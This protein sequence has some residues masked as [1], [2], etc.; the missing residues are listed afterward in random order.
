MKTVFVWLALMELLTPLTT[1]AKLVDK[2]VAI[3]PP[4][5]A[6]VAAGFEH[7]IA[8]I[9][10]IPMGL[11][12]KAGAPASFWSSIGKSPADFP[13]LTWINF[14]FANLLPVTIGNVIGGSIMVG[15]VYWFVYLR[16]ADPFKSRR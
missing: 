13:Q 11:F 5:T 7:C 10:Y 15:A 3:V 9:Y 12:I 1:R 14:F 8:N 16:N 4:I 6:F 2:I